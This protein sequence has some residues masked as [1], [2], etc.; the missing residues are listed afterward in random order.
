MSFWLHES[1][2]TTYLRGLTSQTRLLITLVCIV[3][4]AG[5]AFLSKSQQAAPQLA[6]EDV[7]RNVLGRPASK[8]VKKTRNARPV[9][10]A[11]KA[12]ALPQTLQFFTKAGFYVCNVEQLLQSRSKKVIGYGV[13]VHG[14]FET[15]LK[16]LTSIKN[17][18]A[19]S[20]LR[21]QSVERVDEKKVAIEFVIKGAQS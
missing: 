1:I 3:A 12:Q 11:V 7:L 9:R 2:F 15:L 6:Q 8:R 4:F 20:I 14:S 10:V 5:K 21:V 13:R 18:P 16:F 19:T 17:A